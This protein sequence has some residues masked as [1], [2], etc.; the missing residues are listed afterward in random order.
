MFRID[1]EDPSLAKQLHH[2]EH[3]SQFLRQITSAILL[4]SQAFESVCSTANEIYDRYHS[5]QVRFMSHPDFDA[6]GTPALSA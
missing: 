1:R 5:T 6:S 2:L 4:D 3:I